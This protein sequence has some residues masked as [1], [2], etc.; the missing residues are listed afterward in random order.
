M[1][2]LFSI[3]DWKWIYVSILLGLFYPKDRSFLSERMVQ[4]E[5]WAL[6]HNSLLSCKKRWFLG[7]GICCYLLMLFLTVFAHYHG[8]DDGETAHN[9]Q[10]SVCFFSEHHATVAPAIAGLVYLQPDIS[11]QLFFDTVNL[12]ATFTNPIQSRA[13]PVFSV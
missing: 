4:K 1:D 2:S 9:E 3:C 6:L 10:C 12:P 7:V 13:P 8:C 5:G 11:V